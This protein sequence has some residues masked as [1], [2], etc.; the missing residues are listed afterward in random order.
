MN[1]DVNLVG[2]LSLNMHTKY[3]NYGSA[4]QSY[5]LQKYLGKINVKSVIIDYVPFHATHYWKKNWF[6]SFRKIIHPVSFVKQFRWAISRWQRKKKFSAFFESNYKTT[7]TTYLHDELLTTGISGYNFNAFITGSDTVWK[8]DQ[9]KGFNKVFFLDIPATNDK[10]KIAYAASMGAR[11][12]SEN[13]IDEF[14]KLTAGFK[15]IG[16]R[17]QT[18]VDYVN[19]FLDKPAE[20]VVDP[21]LLLYNIDYE[22]IAKKPKMS[23]YCLL[24]TC[25]ENDRLMTEQARDF[26]R[27]KDLRLI[28]ISPFY[29]NKYD[30]DHKVLN[31]VGIEEWLGWFMNASYVITNSFHGMCFSV[32]FK[33]NAYL[34]ERNKTDSKMPDLCKMLGLEQCLISCDKKQIEDANVQINWTDVNERLDRARKVSYDFLEKM[35]AD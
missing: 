30:Y 34:F 23:G 18:K 26:A 20:R 9:T 5:A 3:L 11:L 31:D 17:E 12:F 22:C 4:L 1:N 24:Y 28:E 15:G 33:K 8:V 35:L 29:N 21:T 25:E 7:P 10:I 6:P 32:I 27:Q 19:Q 2:I 14:I 13:E 16:L